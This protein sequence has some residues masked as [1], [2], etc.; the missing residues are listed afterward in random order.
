MWCRVPIPKMHNVP[1]YVFASKIQSSNSIDSFDIKINTET[2][3][4]QWKSI[5]KLVM[6]C[7]PCQLFPDIHP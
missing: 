4:L 7:G 5:L 3:H 1:K 2:A 6:L